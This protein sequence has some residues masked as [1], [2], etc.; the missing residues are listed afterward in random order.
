MNPAKQLSHHLARHE[1]AAD[2][3]EGTLTAAMMGRGF[4]QMCSDREIA[5]LLAKHGNRSKGIVS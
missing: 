1:A 5:Q 3:A 2:H 4:V